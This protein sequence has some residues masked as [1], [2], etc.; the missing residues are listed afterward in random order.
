MRAVDLFCGC[1]GTLQGLKS[2][3]FA[4]MLGLDWDENALCVCRTNGLAVQKVDLRDVSRAI[5]AV[6]SA[7]PD[8]L[9]ASPPCQDYSCSGK[10]VEGARANMTVSCARIM[11]AVR[12]RCICIENVP[13]MLHARSWEEARTLL[14]EAGYSLVVK[15]VNAAA[16]GVAQSRRRVF[17]IGMLRCS[18][19]VLKRIDRIDLSGVPA[20][21]VTVW[22]CLESVDAHTW[23]FCPRNRH[24]PGVRST[25]LPAPTLRC[26]CLSRPPAKYTRRHDDVGDVRFAHVLSCEDVARISSFPKD[27][28]RGMSR[29]VVGRLVGNC[30]PPKMAETVGGLGMQL[31]HTPEMQAPTLLLGTKR[32]YRRVRASRVRRLVDAGLL[33]H[34]GVKQ[35]AQ[36]EYIVGHSEQGDVALGSVLNWVPP[37]GCRVVLKERASQA[38]QPDDLY[39]YAQSE[40]TPFRSK[41]QF[42]RRTRTMD[43]ADKSTCSEWP[44]P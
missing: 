22:D 7:D 27:Y 2:A 1:G 18:E 11:V 23:Y 38:S 35:H 12:A 19:E 20:E 8:L 28:F 39:L 6:R 21:A 15:H 37:P 40:P 13:E 43:R 9:S 3:G 32:R 26:T 34:G 36:L 31:L 30:V 29:T 5:A 42:E 4:A 10:R 16:C 24:S 33:D 17:V 14:T 41:A 44:T 25:D